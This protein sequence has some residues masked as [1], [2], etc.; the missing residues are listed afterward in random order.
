MI[1]ELADGDTKDGRGT[2]DGIL[3]I[4]EADQYEVKISDLRLLAE[5]D[6]D[7]V[8][9]QTFEEAPVIFTTSYN[10]DHVAVYA[11]IDMSG[12]S[13]VCVSV[14]QLGIQKIQGSLRT[15]LNTK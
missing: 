14:A 11:T 12:I 15:L 9:S 8:A 10:S 1:N 13:K 5:T 4:A 6:W 2:I 7:W 3:Y